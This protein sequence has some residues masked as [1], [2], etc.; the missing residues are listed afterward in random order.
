MPDLTMDIFNGDAFSNVTMT[1]YVNTN[2]PFQPS[3]LGSLGMFN[4]EGVY[5]TQVAFDDED[6][7]LTLISATE[8]GGP[9]EQSQNTKGT[10]RVLSTV[11][12]AREAV[13][14]ADE[15]A[16]VR[17]LGT[18]GQLQ[19]AERLVYKRVEGPVGLRAAL[20]YTKE[21]HRLG[22]IDGIVYDANGTKVLWDYFVHYGV[23]RPAAV[24]FAFSSYTGEDR[25]FGKACTA[26]RR[27]ATK[28]LNGFPL[29]AAM[30]IALCGDGFYDDAWSNKE[31]AK[32]AQVA[33]TGN[34]QA[35]ELI[36]RNEAFDS[37]KYGGIVWVN[38]R[39]SDDGKVAIP[40]DEAR[41]F[42][43]GVP[44]LFNEYNAP[45]DTWD[46]VNTEGLPVYMLQR[47]EN[48]TSSRRT[49]EVQANPL[50]LCL[51]PLHMR[52]LTKS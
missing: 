21:Y 52:R 17:V 45:A 41:F 14:K 49:F 42:Y 28:A 18:A 37:F 23:A 10:L 15:V 22:A 4:A 34:L 26:L 5:S 35:P 9:A 39:G 20:E 48:Q 44:G 51:R 27:L 6:G 12:L 47:P 8:R 33:A 1:N 43:A 40:T 7:A 50:Q 2:V 19:T 29:T 30:P 11:R 32:A 46:F 13:I 3:F 16:G 25:A 24:N 36:S 38:Y 31:T